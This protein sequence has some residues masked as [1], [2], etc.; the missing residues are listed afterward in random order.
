V[1]IQSLKD[2]SLTNRVKFRAATAD[3]QAPGFSIANTIDGDTE[4][5]GWTP[6]RTPDHRNEDHYAVFECSEPFGYQVG[7]NWKSCSPEIQRE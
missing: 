1:Q 4:K 7:R 3:L 5:S 2:P 6:S